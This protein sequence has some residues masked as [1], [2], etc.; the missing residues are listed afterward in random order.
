M[1]S[2]AR[3]LAGTA[4]RGVARVSAVL[5]RTAAAARATP[6]VAARTMVTEA[7]PAVSV[8]GEHL[9]MSV[10]TDGIAIITI[11]SKA[12]KVRYFAC[13]AFLQSQSRPA[14]GTL[15]IFLATR[16]RCFTFY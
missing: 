5:P 12:E 8:P 15:Y 3:S 16:C 10:T 7:L 2:A 4:A 14:A 6:S 13:R 1:A 9:Q 11:D